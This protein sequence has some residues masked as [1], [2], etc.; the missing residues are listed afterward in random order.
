MEFLY[1]LQP[2]FDGRKSFYGKANV[3][4][5]GNKLVL[6]SYTT[7]VAE[8]DLNADENQPKVKINGWYSM[9]TARHINEFLKQYGFNSLSKKDMEGGVIY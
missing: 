2:Q 3:Y 8:I 5:K 6:I 4:K 7:I 1:E 9:T